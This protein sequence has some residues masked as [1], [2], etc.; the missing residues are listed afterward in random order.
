[1]RNLRVKLFLVLLSLSVVGTALAV[2]ASWE[3]SF[4]NVLVSEGRTCENVPGDP[5]G[6]TKYGITIYDVR[7]YLNSHATMRE[8]C[9][10][11]L[12]QAK[13]IYKRHYWDAVG[14]DTLPA[15]LDYSIFD[16][17]VNAGLGRALPTLARCRSRSKEVVDQIR[18]VYSERMA[19]QMGLPARF[20]KFKRGWAR[21]ITS[22][23]NISLSMA[24]VD[25]ATL[26]GNL[27]LIPR[28]GPGKAYLEGEVK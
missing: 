4:Q 14:G 8:V 9:A 1:M 16:Y 18:C 7:K 2:P 24:G 5:G 15:G 20:N 12:E 17:A 10:L 3:R 21:R 25:K 28:H 26:G 22:T 11:T 6:P 27:S 13:T 23:R 19:F